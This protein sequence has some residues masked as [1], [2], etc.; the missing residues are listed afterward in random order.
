MILPLMVVNILG[1]QSN[2]YFYIAWMVANLL[3]AIPQSVS[4][5]LFAEGSHSEENFAENVMKSIKF[6][7]LLLVPAV[8]VLIV[9]AKWILLAFGESYSVNGLHLLWLLSFSSLPRAITFIYLSLL[10]V[11]D[12]LKELVIVRG[13]IAVLVLTLTALIMPSYGIMGVG[14]VWLAVQLVVSITLVIRLV[15][16][17][18]QLPS[19]T[20]S[21]RL[22]VDR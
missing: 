14:Y 20:K 10:R 7:F 5:S 2:A 19:S 11:Q 18:R 4:Q 9:S 12:K 3:S 8:A 1:T 17:V 16:W 13:A 15:A 21:T 6:T 22:I